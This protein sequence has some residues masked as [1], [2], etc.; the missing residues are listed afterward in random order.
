MR[1]YWSVQEE[2]DTVKTDLS[3]RALLGS[4]AASLTARGGTQSSPAG[5][6]TLP[7]VR[8]ITRGPKFHWF[9]YY[10]KLQ[11]DPASRFALGMEVAFEHRSPKPDDT[12]RIGMVD[13]EDNDRWIDLG[14]TRAWN[15]QQGCMLQWLPGSKSQVIFNDFDGRQYVSRILDVRSRETVTL[16]GPIYSVSPDARWAVYPDFS[17]LNDDRPGYGY[18]NIPDPHANVLAPA[19]AGIW[20]MDMKT[21]NIKLILSFA[22]IARYPYSYGEWGGASKHRF[23]HLLFSP[24]GHRFIFLHR[25]KGGDNPE[26]GITRMFTAAPDGSDL[27]LLDPYGDTSHFIWR[28]DTHVM[29]WAFHPAHGR[30]FLLFR[31][32]SGELEAVAPEAMPV[33]GH[34]T[35]LNRDGHRWILN[36]TYPDKDRLQHPYLYDT[37][38]GRRYPLGHFRSPAEYSG[39]WRCDTHPRSNR[40]GK[41]VCIDSPHA[42][43]RQMHLIEIRGIVS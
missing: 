14:E 6:E 16:P 22:Q 36:D 38:T 11:F 13:I 17:R 40:N 8:A 18:P 32:K 28:G 3:R 25:R 1:I 24:S 29:A 43:G 39:E 4:L 30:K 2:R 26:A 15:W 20:L 10:D 7:P 35:Y 34:N 9:G 27:Y 33:N 21:G 23:N 19:K 37:R 31:D 41:L 42:G 12:I 5:G